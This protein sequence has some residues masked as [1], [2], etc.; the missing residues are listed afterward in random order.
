LTSKKQHWRQSI[1][2]SHDPTAQKKN[3]RQTKKKRPVSERKKL[4]I[5]PLD[6][7]PGG[8]WKKGPAQEK[9]SSVTVAA[10]KRGRGR[11][12]VKRMEDYKKPFRSTA[13]SQT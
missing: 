4:K 9:T 3:L 2:T 10:T 12:K 7:D 8:R 13:R 11:V 6:L 1:K 5:R